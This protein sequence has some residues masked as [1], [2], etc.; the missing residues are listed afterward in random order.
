[1]KYSFIGCGN[2][3]GALALALSKATKDI[4]LSDFSAEKAENTA[5][6]LGVMHGNNKQAAECERI[7]LGVKPQVQKSVLDEIEPILKT[8]KPLLITM[9]AGIEIKTVEATVGKLPIIRIMPN[10]PVAVGKGLILYCA[11]ELVDEKTLDDFLFD[12]RF[13]GVLDKIDE[14]LIDAGCSVSGCGPAYM[15]M[16]IEALADGGVACGLPRDKAIKYAAQT[17]LGSA[18]TVL[19]TNKHPEALKDAVCSPAGSTIAGV[20]ALED[21]GFRASAANAV[22]EAYKRNKELGK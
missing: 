14:K 3:G 11:N 12:M 8:K 4:L 20:K 15:Y 21:G 17:M 5:R 10:T 7:F 13:A 16:M 22:I 2:M 1:M 9:A 19:E 18:A 6:E